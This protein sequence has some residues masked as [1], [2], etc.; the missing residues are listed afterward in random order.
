MQ[1]GRVL[2][3]GN[4]LLVCDGAVRLSCYSA[5]SDVMPTTRA[6]AYI[7]IACD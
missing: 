5:V 7:I 1:L 3:Y 6:Y 2:C 4:K